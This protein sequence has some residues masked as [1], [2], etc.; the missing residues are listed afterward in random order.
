MVL[1]SVSGKVV[2]AKYDFAYGGKIYG[3]QGG[4]SK[5]YAAKSVGWIMI[6]KLIEWGIAHGY[7]EYDFLQGAATYKSQWSNG[8]R[9]V[10]DYEA[11]NTTVRGQAGR[12]LRLG[13]RQ[14][15]RHFRKKV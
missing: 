1:M 13:F 11:F 7:G 15:R 9:W 10:S 12:W 3:N 2:S 14:M 8:E 5:E 4:W 6:G